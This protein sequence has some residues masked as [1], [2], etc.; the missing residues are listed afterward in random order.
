M[1]LDHV[2]EALADA[3]DADTAAGLLAAVLARGNGA[4]FQRR[5]YERAGHLRDVVASA[6]AATAG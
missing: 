4:A 2:G 3:G 1:L 5:A 6:V